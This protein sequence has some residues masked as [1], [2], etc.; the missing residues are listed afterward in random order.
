[1]TTHLE[2]AQ[3]PVKRTESMRNDSLDENETK[4][5]QFGLNWRNPGPAHH[6]ANTI[7]AANHGGGSIMGWETGQN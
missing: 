4:T 6:L 3:K 2:F 5:E 7:P 1:M